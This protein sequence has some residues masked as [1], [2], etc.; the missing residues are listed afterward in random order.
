[1]KYLWIESLRDSSVIMNT[2]VYHCFPQD[3]WSISSTV[4]WTAKKEER[5]L[6]RNDPFGE[7]RLKKSYSLRNACILLV[8]IGGFFQYGIS[9]VWLLFNSCFMSSFR[10]MTYQALCLFGILVV[11]KCLFLYIQLFDRRKK[12]ESFRYL[13]SRLLVAYWPKFPDI[14]RQFIIPMEIGN[15][16]F[17]IKES[18]RELYGIMRCINVNWYHCR[19]FCNF[20]MLSML[21]L[22]LP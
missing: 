7:I 3:F 10:M 15:V 14:K 5:N 19:L 2:I 21:V 9:N 6:R 17:W 22:I 8:L 18:R 16:V 20:R 13:E 1:M 11:N 4:Y 12:I